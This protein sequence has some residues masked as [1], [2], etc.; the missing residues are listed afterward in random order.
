M[1]VSNSCNSGFNSPEEAYVYVSLYGLLFILG[2]TLNALALWVFCC[3]MRK[4]TETQVYMVNLAV[5]DGC[6]VLVFPI[7]IYF[8]KTSCFEDLSCQV[9]QGIY[10]VNV[11]MSICI[12]TAIGMDRYV[13][14]KYPLKAKVLRTPGR[15]AIVC[16]LLWVVVIS[17]MAF[18][19]VWQIHD[20]AFCFHKA[21]RI[22]TSV[23]LFSMLGFFL[24]LGILVFCTLQIV[25]T[26]L[27]VQRREI[28]E[29]RQTRK[30]VSMVLANL[31]VFV[32]CFLPLHLSI[33]L[34]FFLGHN[35]R[36][37]KVFKIVTLLSNTNCC[38]DAICYYFV[39][40]EFQQVNPFFFLRCRQPGRVANQRQELQ[41]KTCTTLL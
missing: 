31:A 3:R 24:P 26:L 20:D 18:R 29:I 30:S 35:D 15:A 4:W 25:C 13:A 9:P 11:Y 7:V 5:A 19:V 21:T 22:H 27:K 33:V 8:T 36:F 16:A 23:A 34:N 41:D 14:I 1:N 10:L 6:L 17:M 28:S 40:K 32:I 2:L 39:A 12:P 38:L 37:K